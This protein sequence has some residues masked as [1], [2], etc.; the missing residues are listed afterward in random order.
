VRSLDP[1]LL[2]RLLAAGFDRERF[3]GLAA[4]LTDGEAPARR[5]L[6]NT[7]KGGVSAP[8]PGEIG[9]LPEPGSAEHERLRA[10]G[11]A[12]LASGELA[13]CVMAG[14]MATR[15]GGIVKALAEVFDGHT[16]LDLRLRENR[17]ASLRAGRPIPFWLMTSDATHEALTTTLAKLGAPS[18][19]ACF[20]QELSLRLCPDGT[21]FYDDDGSPSVYATG[22]GDLVDAL[23]RSTLLDRF[24]ESG[25][26]YVWITN[27][28]NLGA[29]IDEVVLGHF[30]E[31]TARGIDVQGEMCPK[32]G[33][34]GGIPVRAEGKL[35]VLEEF[36]LPPDF[37]P[38]TVDVFNTNT[39]LVR[40]EPLAKAALTWT[41]F[42]V[43]K[44]VSGRPAIQFERLVQEITAHLPSTYVRVPREG[45]ASRFLPVKDY[46]EL[47]RR[48][49]DIRLVAEARGML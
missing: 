23:R 22:H 1:A 39:F 8:L 2:R 48:T 18:H 44:Q 26:K 29:S 37:D 21:L 17:T 6:R 19:V 9:Q 33:D 45:A 25:G 34:K 24:I 15:M 36:R 20:M 32:A 4:T 14:G 35:Q 31:A 41:F 7:V 30:I 49:A 3:L 46:D 38:K 11:A 13:F 12:S 27:L 28:D 40:A 42:E 47:A 16:F 10:L 43:E 5:R